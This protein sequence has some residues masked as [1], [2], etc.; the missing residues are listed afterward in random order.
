MESLLA[1]TQESSSV[2]TRASS[3]RQ[4]SDHRVGG[5]AP[6]NREVNIGAYTLRWRQYKC[7][8]RKIQFPF[9]KNY[10]EGSLVLLTKIPK[11]ENPILQV[12]GDNAFWT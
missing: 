2:E 11:L 9:M 8:P 3:R 1:F 12:M 5:V 10:H 6:Q 4:V 7:P